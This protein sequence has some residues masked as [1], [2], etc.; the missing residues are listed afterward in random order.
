M[1]AY[2]TT[3]SNG[4]DSDNLETAFRGTRKFLYGDDVKHSP[5]EQVRFGLPKSTKTSLL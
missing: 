3:N 5:G 1:H 2:L 4:G